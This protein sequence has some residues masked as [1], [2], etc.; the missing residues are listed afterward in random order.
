MPCHAIGYQVLSNQP[1]STEIGNFPRGGKYPKDVTL[2]TCFN[3]LQQIK[4]IILDWYLTK[5]KSWMF[6]LVVKRL[7]NL[8]ELFKKHHSSQSAS[9]LSIYQSLSF[10]IYF[11]N[12]IFSKFLIFFSFF[13]FKNFWILNFNLYLNLFFKIFFIFI[14][15]QF[16][17]L[18]FLKNTFSNHTIKTKFFQVFSLKKYIFKTALSKKHFQ[19][20]FL[21]KCIFKITLSQHAFSKWLPQK[22]TFFKKILFKNCSLKKLFSQK[23][24]F[25]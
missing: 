11:S 12:F 23:N 9:N 21:K 6:L 8:M 15:F 3:Y 16:F 5:S 18:I 20:C 19:N 14:F 24:K 1:L 2:S 4:S 25:S 13:V 22:N 17:V 10:K 7:V